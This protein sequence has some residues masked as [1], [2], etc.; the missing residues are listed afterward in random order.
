MISRERE[1]GMI[2]GIVN[3]LLG[4]KKAVEKKE[5]RFKLGNGLYWEFDNVSNGYGGYKTVNAYL[6]KMDD[7]EFRR[8]IVD[9]DGRIQNFP[10]FKDRNWENKLEI[11]WADQRVIFAFWISPY[12]DGRAG[13]RW[14]IQPDG[15]YFE[16]EDGYG[17]ERCEEIEVY[18]Y[19]DEEGNFTEP[20]CC[21]S[22]H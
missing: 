5:P 6:L 21:R 1:N 10:G 15:R 3:R 4:Q 19:L 22:G 18:S 11:A 9:C 12:Q 20:F 16:D 8:C 14:L 17:A 7:P 2:K 13:V